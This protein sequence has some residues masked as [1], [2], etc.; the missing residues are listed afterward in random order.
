MCY[1]DYSSEVLRLF[2][3]SYMSEQNQTKKTKETNKQKKNN[4][5][6]HA[7]TKQ[8]RGLSPTTMETDTQDFLK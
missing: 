1:S 4:E 2:K 6:N 5:N 3:W 7:Q 8:K